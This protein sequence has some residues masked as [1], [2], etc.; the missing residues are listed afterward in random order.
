MIETINIEEGAEYQLQNLLAFDNRIRDIS[1]FQKAKFDHL[2]YFILQNNLLGSLDFNVFENM[3]KL[4]KIDVKGN[5]LKKLV[6]TMEGTFESLTYLD[7]E[8]N[9]LTYIDLEALRPFSSLETLKLSKNSLIELN[10]EVIPQYFRHIRRLVVRD[11]LWNCDH[12]V[13]MIIFFQKNDVDYIKDDSCA[14]HL[15]DNVCCYTDEELV[16][17]HAEAYRAYR[18]YLSEIKKN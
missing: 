1:I 16:T 7:V 8:N 13:E 18:E 3:K 10:Y 15:F 6:N 12:I 4:K 14:G 11:N 17:N 2:E 9:S 5:G